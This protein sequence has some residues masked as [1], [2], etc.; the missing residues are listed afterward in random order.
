MPSA[1]SI[2]VAVTALAASGVQA[3][4]CKPTSTTV[5]STTTESA[6][7]TTS[8]ACVETETIEE[9]VLKDD[10]PPERSCGVKGQYAQ[11][12]LPPGPAS[13]IGDCAQSCIEGIEGDPWDCSLIAYYVE[14]QLAPDVYTY[15]YMQ[16]SKNPEKLNT[17]H[18]AHE[19]TAVA[20]FL[21]GQTSREERTLIRKLDRSAFANAYVAGLKEA[22]DL[23]GNQYNVLL[24]MAS[25]GM[26]VGQI[27]SSIIIQKVRPRIWLSSMVIVWAGL[28]MASAGCKTY[29]QLCAVRFLMGL[30]EASTYAGSIY[31]MGSW[32][33]SDEIAKRTAT[34]TVAGQVGK[35]FAGAMMAAIH[36]S[37]EGHAGL[38]GWQWVFLIDGII[39]C[40][41]AIFGFLYFPDVP[42]YTQA[43]YLNEKEQQLALDRLPPKN[44]DGHNIQAWSLCKRVLGQ[45]L[46]YVCCIFSVLS[47]SLQSYIVQ[48]LMLLY[49]KFHQGD[50]GFSQSQVNTYPIATHAIGIVAELSSSFFIDRYNTRLTIGFILCAIQ[51]VSSIVLLIPDMSFAGTLTT[52]YLAGSAYGINPLLYGWSSNIAARTADD[53]A[54]SV[55]LAS[56]AASDG[57]LWT[58][59]GIVLY[60]ADDA[61]Y[62]RNGYISMICVSVALCCWLFVVRWLD[63]YT[64]EKY[65]QVVEASRSDLA[66]QEVNLSVNEK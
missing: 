3:G 23:S 58:F 10:N 27:P 14:D 61:P 44:E 33:K 56:M 57:L 20:D 2:A 19:N 41:I 45:P 22:L 31:I 11:E 8:S 63:R 13:S 34:F 28:T 48:G 6:T 38:A 52:L 60:P 35:M 9:Y 59:W 26:L 46:I 24:S 21:W 40:P 18:M 50:Y 4:A 39:T 54:R 55:I 7:S 47:T 32:Y 66:V 42:E 62:W 12:A 51:I 16:H 37:M 30:A 64:A 1:K 29:A 43:P 5:L 53:A 49:M 65:P 25:A 36:E 15:S 17:F